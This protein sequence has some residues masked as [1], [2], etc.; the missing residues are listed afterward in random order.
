MLR[1]QLR[2]TEAWD[3]MESRFKSYGGITVELEHSLY[4]VS[5]YERLKKKPFI[6]RTGLDAKELL[7]YIANCM[8]ITPDVPTESWLALTNDQVKEITDYIGDPYCATTV[9]PQPHNNKR[10]KAT[11]AE[12]IYASMFS[13][14]IP[15]E[16]EHW[17]F[18]RLNTLLAVC[19]DM[20]T[21]PKKM[22]KKDMFEQQRAQNEAMKKLYN[23]R[24]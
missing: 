10:K 15:L 7:F 21:P 22:S 2:K 9:K 18:N 8:C 6:Q 13:F 4:T 23:S 19:M 14:G 5:I 12:T 17:H 1:L 11:T 24:G 3:E 16:L 20:N